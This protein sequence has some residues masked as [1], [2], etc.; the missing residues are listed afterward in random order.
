[1]SAVGAEIRIV[2]ATECA[3]EIVSLVT[4]AVHTHAFGCA[5]FTVVN[6]NVW[7]A[8]GIVGHQVGSGRDKRHVASIGADGGGR[9]AAIP[10]GAVTGPPDARR[11]GVATSGR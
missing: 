10:L 2:N 7:N 5:G 11:G 4:R 6:E 8:V 1:M 3:T 9:A